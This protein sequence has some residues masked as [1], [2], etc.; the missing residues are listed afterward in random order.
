MRLSP[1]HHLY[2]AL[3]ETKPVGGTDAAHSWTGMM[4]RTQKRQL[5]LYVHFRDRHMSVLALF[6]FNWRLY[7][8][9]L[10]AGVLSVAAMIHLGAP[11][12]AWAFALAYSLI[13]LR[14]AG[15]F[16]RTSRA[17]PMVRTV[18]DWSKVDELSKE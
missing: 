17:W 16:L 6:R 2:E 12:F 14:D 10:I 13:V 3:C 1:H 4:N 7:V 5:D 18:L 15:A 11:L 8:F 9:M